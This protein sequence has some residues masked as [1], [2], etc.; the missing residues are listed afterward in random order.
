MG[1]PKRMVGGRPPNYHSLL[2]L[3][4]PHDIDL[5]IDLDLDL[6]LDL[7]FILILIL[8][9]RLLLSQIVATHGVMKRT[10]LC[11]AVQA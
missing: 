8:I 3:F 11:S 5:D 6:D 7:V 2:D 4:Y 9:F 10:S 1:E